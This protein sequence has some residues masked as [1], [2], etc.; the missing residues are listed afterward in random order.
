MILLDEIEKAHAEVLNVLLQ[1]LDDG[2]LTDGHGRTVDFRNTI[3]IMTSNLG[4]Q[5]I[6]DLADD[7]K[8]MESRVQQVVR[9]HFRPELLNRIDEVVVFH[10]LSREQLRA[11]VDLQAGGLRAMLA[12]RRL[13]LELSDAARD[14]LVEEGWDPNFGARPLKR[15]IVRRVQNALALQLLRGEFKDGDVI[16]VDHR[17]GEF[18]FEHAPKEARE[19][20]REA[21]RT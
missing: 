19:A 4:S 21:A 15:T 5:Y 8:E 2:R 10:A 13:G 11:I 16:R 17:D 20:A 1:L 7:P 18:V 6:L 14:A 3:V 12:E 9:Q